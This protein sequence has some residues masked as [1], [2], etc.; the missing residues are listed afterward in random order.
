MRITATQIA[1]WA[2]TKE[3]QA[4][5]PRLIRGLV[6]TAGTPTEVDFPAGDSTG[7]PGW[8]GELVSEHGSS[9]VPKGKSFWELSCHGKPT[10][11][12]NRDYEKR[13]RQTPKNIRTGATFVVV[14]ARRWSGK[15]QWLKAK[16]RTGKWTDVRAYNA[17]DIEQWLEQNPPMALQFGEEIGLIGQGVE[18]LA[19]HWKDWSQQSDPSISVE[20]L[21]IDRQNTRDRFLADLQRRLEAGQPEPYTIRADSVDEAAAFVCSVLLAQPHLSV[22]SLVVTE[23][24]GWRFVEQNQTLKVVLAARPEIAEKPTR[25]SGLCVIIPY[26]A[27]DMTGY[28]RGAAGRDG[29]ADLILE[30]PRT[31]EFEKALSSIGLDEADANR[32]AVSTGR[33]WSVFRRRRAVNPAI[34][35]PT[36]LD[37]PQAGALST[38]CLLGA[39]STN[40]AADRE[41][42]TQLS[43]RAYEEVE[44]DLRYLARVD[45]APVLEIGEVWK[46][47]SSLE[48]LDLFGDRITRDEL[49]RFFEVARRIL[50]AP[51][52]E[53]ELP[54]EER[55]AA[56][57]YGKVRPQSGLLIRALCD[58][59]IKLAVRDLQAPVLL[60]S[61]IEGRIA[62]F[63]RELLHDA[64]GARWLSL[65]SFLPSLAESAPDTFL[66]AV[67]LSLARPDAP[68]T[69]LLTETS[70]SG[71]MGR[72]WHSGLLW[73]LETLAWAP[74]RL[75]RVVLVL[76]ALTKVEIKGN[77]GNSPKATLLNIF[78]S[79]L[80]Q[81]AA[82]ADYR[83]TVLDVLIA[84]EPD[85]A[86]D[87]LDRLVYV[88]QDTSTPSA[89]PKWRDDDAGAGHGI[90]TTE[91]RGMLVAAADRLIA[92]SE[93]HPHRIARVIEKIGV[94]DAARIK[95]ILRLAGQ[96]ARSSASDEDR[97]FIRTSLRKRIY[98]HRNYDK[99]RGKA[100]D[101]KLADVEDLY[102]RL[103][104]EDLVVRHRWLFAAGWPNLPVRVRDDDRTRNEELRETWR[105]DALREVY[106]KRGLP[107]IEQLA[108]ACANQPYV[109]IA[110]AKLEI[111][112]TALAEW[113][114]ERG[115]D[116]TSREPLMMT[117]RGLLRAS[118]APRSMELITAV[119]N[120]GGERNWDAPKIAR[121]LV[122]AREE[123]T[124]WEIAAS[125]GSEVE[126]NYW[127][128]TDAGFWLRD[129]RADFAL[130]R[131]LDVGRPRS[132]LQASH[133]DL[134]KMDAKLLAEMLERMLKGE[135]P[136]GV[137]LD[138][139]HIGEAVDRLEA[140]GEI[141]RDRLV[142][143]EFGL[144][145]A[146]GFE[147][148]Q[149]AKSLYDAIM[150]DPK[151]FTELLCILYKPANGEP[152]EPPSEVTKAVAQ[153]AWHVLHHCG[154]QPGTQPD[155]TI[156]RDAF[157]RF[158]DDARELCRQADRLGPCDSTLGQILAYAPADSGGVWPFEPARDVLDRPELEGMRHG[159]QIGARNK[160]GFTTRAY[161]DGGDQERKLADTYRSHARAL[162]TSHVN[163]AATL[164]ELARSYEK[165][166]LRQDQEANL[167]REG[168]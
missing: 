21:L 85:V 33:S 125:C 164:E 60:A 90:P 80:P 101:K 19:K 50:L 59:L 108:V 3:A 96:F 64:D 167:R 65:S 154:R 115:G 78:R 141:D 32:L 159:F 82:G 107:G 58:T 114:V 124:T 23:P 75:T 133:L 99:V 120:R 151:L 17:D 15:A 104:P 113:I 109:G 69:R 142:R 153:T 36:W 162:H 138:S 8:D 128:T 34:R 97:D 94:F 77:W 70:G 1:E 143:L 98:W 129:D 27:G 37:A 12:A 144:I 146:L 165:D 47:K 100:L 2:K 147:G 137:L 87:L 84:K 35:K 51:D 62:A 79:W 111:E 57:V 106:T 72:C 140:S 166:G 89:R 136:D 95:A 26:A 116:L 16:R 29:N 14:S 45:D 67:E 9:W 56:Q 18:S 102:E 145:P 25:R 5:L 160:R 39:W 131:L 126:G 105:I 93:G 73:A 88:G 20:A 68:V 41:I 44:R 103:L 55:Y 152:G 110:L 83:I 130:R 158:I 134:D 43:G 31:H 112:T 118:A 148:E 4:S 157:V 13:T 119:L 71:F 155:G 42:V 168:Y 149:R 11:K 22:A 48:L 38:L 76:A 123:P 81:T 139:W 6:H 40:Q 91:Y 61:N 52:P 49:D 30:R 24:G 10:T 117:I 132:A 135:E 161:D 28:Y 63:V 92:Q 86:F 53:L 163:V 54:D 74:E 121:L 156:D 46:A 127:A 150:S 7:L 66:K 122:L